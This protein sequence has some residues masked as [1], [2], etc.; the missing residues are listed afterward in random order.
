MAVS[1]TKV[2]LTLASP[3]A[4]GNTVTIAYTKPAAN[5]LQTPAGGQAASFTAKSVTNRISEPPPPPVIIEP[6]ATQNSAPVPVISYQGFTYA[7]FEGVMDATGSY[8][9]NNDQLTYSWVVPSNIPVST[10]TS[11]VL[12]FLGPVTDVTQNV[13]FTLKISDGKITESKSIKVKILPYEPELKAAEVINVEASAF[14]VPYYPHNII[15]GDIGTM[16]VANGEDQWILLEL[17]EL[18]TVQHIKLAFQ[19][20]LKDEAYFDI[21]GSEDQENWEPI[22]LKSKSCAFSGNL[23]VFEFPPSKTGKEFKYVKLIG[24]GNATNNWNY[25]SEF[26][27]FGYNRN[28]F[29]DFS[30]QIAKIYPNPARDFTNIMI[31]E[32]G[33]VPDYIKITT[34]SGKPVFEDKLDPDI[35][36]FQIPLKVKQ[37]VYIVLL[38]KNKVPMFTQKLVVTN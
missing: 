6:P 13:E 12:K 5:P 20:G 10:L 26:R 11:P 29:S 22:L 3:V 17:K 32:P 35:S 9:P 34:L 21:Y 1:G 14:Q 2:S 31:M 18:F 33:F 25:I 38:G 23:Q 30:K 7:G 19:P 8:D 4:Y 16:W 36:Q 24:R 37:G 15:D 27:I 28:E